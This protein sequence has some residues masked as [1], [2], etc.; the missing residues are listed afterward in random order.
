MQQHMVFV[1]TQSVAKSNF[2]LQ[3]LLFVLDYRETLL[4]PGFIRFRKNDYM[5]VDAFAFSTVSFTL[6]F[7][8][9]QQHLVPC[10]FCGNEWQTLVHI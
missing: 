9:I 10:I 8:G 5:L 7:A 2:K 6:R 3:L 4:W 1:W